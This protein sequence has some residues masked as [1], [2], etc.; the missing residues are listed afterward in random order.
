MYTGRYQLLQLHTSLQAEH[1]R[2][3]VHTGHV[4]VEA[5]WAAIIIDTS[6][7]EGMQTRVHSN[8]RQVSFCSFSRQQQVSESSMH[9]QSQQQ[10][11]LTC[12]GA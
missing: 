2:R 12:M 4:S 11:F 7:M 5:G 8:A 1:G 10:L 6:S 3:V 9:T